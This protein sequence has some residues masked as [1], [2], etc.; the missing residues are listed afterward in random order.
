MSNRIKRVNQLLKRQLGRIILKEVSFP[1]G[2]L[3]T[4]T[5]V[6]T[7]TDLGEAKVLVSVFPEKKSKEALR[8]LNKRIYHLQQR[9]N[10]ILNLKRVP[11]IRF[12]LDRKIKQAA[13]IEEL[14]EK[15]EKEG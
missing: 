4:I 6:E 14:L 1:R 5:K 15:I 12:L 8:V 2:C 10:K 11:K 3:A 7:S 13:R 9:I